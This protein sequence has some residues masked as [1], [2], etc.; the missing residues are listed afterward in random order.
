MLRIIDIYIYTSNIH[1]LVYH[2]YE[3]AENTCKAKSK[4]KTLSQ[5]TRKTSELY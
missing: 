1:P 5:N 3:D 2:Y 4:R